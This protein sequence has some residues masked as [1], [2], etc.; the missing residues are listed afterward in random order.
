MASIESKIEDSEIVP[1]N[2]NTTQ[3]PRHYNKLL[4]IGEVL[5]KQQ[6]VT[7]ISNVKCCK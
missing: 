7:S 3:K 5:G 4:S 1:T 6:G 2:S